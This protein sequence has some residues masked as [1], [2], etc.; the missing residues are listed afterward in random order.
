MHRE[1]TSD[2][3]TLLLTTGKGKGALVELVLNLIPQSGSAQ[4]LL[5]QL[6]KL[7]LILRP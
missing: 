7:L 2:A 6:V 1:R 4:A 3:Q 5:H